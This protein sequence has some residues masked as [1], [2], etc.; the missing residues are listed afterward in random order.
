MKLSCHQASVCFESRRFP[1]EDGRIST[2]KDYYEGSDDI[3]TDHD[4][5][6]PY[7]FDDGISGYED[8]TRQVRK[9]G[10]YYLENTSSGKKHYKLCE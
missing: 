3:R 9:R 2:Y 5:I 8:N 6:N 1:I 7:Y 10:W 4:I